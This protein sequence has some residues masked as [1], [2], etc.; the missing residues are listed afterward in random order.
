MFNPQ[1][2]S[3]GERRRLQQFLL[4]R[5]ARFEPQDIDRIRLI[6]AQ[7]LAGRVPVSEKLKKEPF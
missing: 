6:Q 3:E 5:G 7:K 4:Q 1:A 2:A